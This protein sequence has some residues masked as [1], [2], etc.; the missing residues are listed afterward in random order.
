[1]KYLLQIRLVN[2]YMKKKLKRDT[3]KLRLI[4]NYPAVYI[5]NEEGD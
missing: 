2:K 3:K 4:L 5:N 1:M